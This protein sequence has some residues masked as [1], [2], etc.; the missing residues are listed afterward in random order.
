MFYIFK[1]DTCVGTCSGDPN[2]E[3]LESRG[4]IA[5]ESDAVYPIDQ[6]I[7]NNEG[8]VVKKPVA[9]LTANEIKQQKLSALD[10]EYQTQFNALVQALGAAT[11]ASDTDL[12]ADLQTEYT[13]LKAEYTAVRS[14]IENG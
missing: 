8:N 2:Y 13:A 12:I 4:E 6:V 14:V 9:E 5:I 11:L 10:T 7:K 3:D 1:G